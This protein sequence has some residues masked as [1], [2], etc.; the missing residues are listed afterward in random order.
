[1]FIPHSN[2]VFGFF[3]FTVGHIPDNCSD[4]TL[5]MANVFLVGRIAGYLSLNE[6]T[7]VLFDDIPESIFLL[8]FERFRIV[9]LGIIAFHFNTNCC[10]CSLLNT[11]FDIA[12]NSL[13]SS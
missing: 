9:Q 8:Y 12:N 10:I 11:S 7:L 2:Y 13:K 6:C 3:K 1:M 4:S 5:I